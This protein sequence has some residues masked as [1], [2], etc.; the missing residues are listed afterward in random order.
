[1]TSS[2]FFLSTLKY[3][4]R[5]TTHQKPW[6]VQWYWDGRDCLMKD[7]KM[8]MMIRGA[9]DRLWW[10]KIWC[11]Q[12]KEKIRENRRFTITPL[13]LQFSSNFRVSFSQNCVWG[14]RSLYSC[15]ASQAASFCGEWV[16]ELVQRYE[17]CLNNGGNYVEKQ[18]TVCTSNG[19]V[20]GL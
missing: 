3:D 4:A 19:N 6:V 5:S 12:L 14:Q 7:A 2:W 13:S 17:K 16:Q 10:T 15:F 1:M 8:C 18:C 9:A 20:Q 11:L